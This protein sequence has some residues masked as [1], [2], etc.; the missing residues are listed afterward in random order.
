MITA[1]IILSLMIG[2]LIFKANLGRRSLNLDEDLIPNQL[3]TTHPVVFLSGRKSLFYFLNYWNNIPERIREHGY[4]VFELSLPWRNTIESRSHLSRFIK[5]LEAENKKVHVFADP[6]RLLE[7][8]SL[9]EDSSTAIQSLN[10][11]SPNDAIDFLNTQLRPSPQPIQNHIY[12]CDSKPLRLFWRI[13]IAA[14]KLTSLTRHFHPEILGFTTQQ[15]RI[16][17]FYLKVLT[18]LA[19]SDLKR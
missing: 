5:E 6:S 16:E 2:F 13:L 11:V 19:L 3:L 4:E 1:I 8:Q 9:S 10:L 14:H 7:L 12:P 18:D 17:S 15:K